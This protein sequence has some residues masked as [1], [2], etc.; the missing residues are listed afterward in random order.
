MGEGGHVDMEK[1]EG[2][3]DRGARS[4][5]TVPVLRKEPSFSRWCGEVGANI[6]AELNNR[7]KHGLEDGDFELP[8]LV[9]GCENGVSDSDRINSVEIDH[10]DKRSNSFRQRSIHL[11]GCLTGDDSIS[12]GNSGSPRNNDD[13][14]GNGKKFSPFYVENDSNNRSGSPRLWVTPP[15][16]RSFSDFKGEN[17]DL[18][19][20]SETNISAATVIRTLLL[21]LVWYTF[22]TCLT[23]YN[24]TLL[25]DHLGKFPAPFLMNTVHFALQALLSKAILWFWSERFENS[26]IMSWRDYFIRVVP[27]ALGTALDINL[28]NAS[29]VFI[30]VTFATM[31][32]SAAPVFLLL[33]AFAFKLESP[34]LKLFGIIFVISTGVLLT[35][36]KETE[37]EFWGFLFVMLAAVM[38]GFRWSMTQILLQRET[39]GLKNPITLMSYVTPVMTLVTALLSLI[40]DPWTHF[41][42]NYYFN[43]SWHVIRSCL[44]MLFG[45]GLAFFMVLT[46]Y[47]LVSATSAVTV[48][49]AGV[50]KEAVTIVVA[51]FYFHDEFTLLKGFG[52]LTIM[53]GVSLFNWYKYQKLQKGQLGHAQYFESS[54]TNASV[55]YVILDNMDE[56]A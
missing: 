30:S 25:G 51:V 41:K 35:V 1:N 3:E 46:E 10:L 40:F 14:A 5:T 15:R 33:F 37:F 11:N 55:K 13:V 4:E 29:L 43:G 44:L 8:S 28:S 32:K 42:Q 52:L 21:V 16:E 34:S 36:A 48:T 26:G 20:T 24:K 22:S 56:E 23:L 19:G 17:E 31:C 2:T 45:G 53:V 50:V 9:D 7:P 18:K 49:I 47:I 39:C 54:N 12:A 38:S 6:S 27:T